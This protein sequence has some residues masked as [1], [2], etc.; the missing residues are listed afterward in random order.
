MVIATTTPDN[1][2]QNNVGMYCTNEVVTTNIFHIAFQKNS[3][4]TFNI[5]ALLQC[6]IGY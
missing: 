1:T 3:V 2:C 4:I 5:T 6:N